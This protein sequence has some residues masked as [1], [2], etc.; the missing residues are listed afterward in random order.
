MAVRERRVGVAEILDYIERTRGSAPVHIPLAHLCRGATL[1]ARPDGLFVSRV[2]TDDAFP[3]T[4]LDELGWVVS[5]IAKERLGHIHDVHRASRRPTTSRLTPSKTLVVY[6]VRLMDD[7]WEGRFKR[8]NFT[9]RDLRAARCVLPVKAPPNARPRNA[10]ICL[11]RAYLKVFEDLSGRLAVDRSLQTAW[12]AGRWRWLLGILGLAVTISLYAILVE[13]PSSLAEFWR[14]LTPPSSELTL[15]IVTILP[16]F[17]IFASYL[18]QIVKWDTP[19]IQLL[20]SSVL[21]YEYAAP[22]NRVIAQVTSQPVD[23]FS[24]VIA[25]LKTKA[26]GEVHR[27]A[28]HQTW[29][30]LAL[31]FAG[32]MFAA[33][34][35]R[36]AEERP[37]T[38]QTPGAEAERGAEDL[39]AARGSRLAPAGKPRDPV[40]PDVPAKSDET[41]GSSIASPASHHESAQSDTAAAPRLRS[42]VDLSAVGGE[43]VR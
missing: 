40:L 4:D 26:D 11:R 21:F 3:A 7:G 35:I 32:L 13:W 18:A 14:S 1:L 30:A 8:A 34:A 24:D 22:L 41:V 33:L 16:A 17:Y 42:R 10:L 5:G 36:G 39:A 38:G 19:R 43:S 37:L 20:R 25:V 12:Q 6:P 27:T 31:G 29:L 23:G 28:V 2:E 15:A 9:D